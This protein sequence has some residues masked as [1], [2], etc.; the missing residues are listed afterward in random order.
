MFVDCNSFYWFL[1]YHNFCDAKGFVLDI[2][3]FL[4]NVSYW[5]FGCLVL[6]AIAFVYTIDYTCSSL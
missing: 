1:Y 3:M 2:W 4:L 6:V 5:I